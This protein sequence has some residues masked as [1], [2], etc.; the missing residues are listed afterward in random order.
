MFQPV[1][2]FQFA[3][4]VAFIASGEKE[5]QT[6]LNSFTRWCLWANFVIGV[7]KFVT[8]GAKNY[9][10]RAIQFQLSIDKQH[11]PPVQNGKSFKYLGRYFDFDMINEMHKSI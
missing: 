9:S 7:D 1:H 4:D 5:N 10:I 3:D 11:A 6:L 2:W 8:F